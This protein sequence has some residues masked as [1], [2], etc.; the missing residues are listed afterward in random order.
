[1][2]IRLYLNVK[3][4]MKQFL[5]TTFKVRSVLDRIIKVNKILPD[6]DKILSTC[7]ICNVYIFVFW[8]YYLSDGKRLTVLEFPKNTCSEQRKS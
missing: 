4:N 3:L 8:I 7:H 2:P 5:F 6:V 1:M